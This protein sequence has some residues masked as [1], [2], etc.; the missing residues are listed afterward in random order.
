MSGKTDIDIDKILADLKDLEKRMAGHREPWW[1]PYAKLIS[2]VLVT[3]SKS[4]LVG[5]MFGLGVHMSGVL[6]VFR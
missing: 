5:L 1:F 2:M 6:E 3:T 4:F